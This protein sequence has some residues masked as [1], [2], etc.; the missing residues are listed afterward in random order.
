[1]RI[2]VATGLATVVAVACGAIAARS[3]PVAA[4]SASGLSATLPKQALP[5]AVAKVRAR[6][7]AAAVECDYAKLQRI[8]LERGKGFTFSY[9]G[10]H[11]A[12]AYWRKLETTHADRP[13]ARLVRILRLP[14]TRN[15][16]GSFAWPSAYTDKPTAADWNALVRGGVYTRA[17]AERMRKSGNVYLGYRTA[18]TRTGDWQFFV[19]G[20]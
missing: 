15:E 19:A 20:D 13:L 3:A 2:A 14:V 9:G 17:Q 16:T 6:I 1:M 10:E 5:A 11:S 4:C 8:A 7:A 18:I 12:A